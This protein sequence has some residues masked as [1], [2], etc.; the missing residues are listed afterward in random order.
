MIVK[1]LRWRNLLVHSTFIFWVLICIFGFV[2]SSLDFNF[3]SFTD[4]IAVFFAGLLAPFV[5]GWFT[6]LTYLLGF[7]PYFEQN[8][9][10]R[11]LLLDIPFVF[12]TFFLFL[13]LI[14]SIDMGLFELLPLIGYVPFSL[15]YY[16]LMPFLIAILA[17]TKT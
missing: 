16:F 9:E 2:E 13:L 17:R 6:V 1:L 3:K 11:L 8:K 7:T 10:G 4:I 15:L 14:P 5:I 12:S